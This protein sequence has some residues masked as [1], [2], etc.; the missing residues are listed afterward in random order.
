MGAVEGT[1]AFKCPRCGA[2]TWGNLKFCQECGQYLNVECPGC[3]ATWRYIHER[4]YCP[5]CGTK[6]GKP[7]SKV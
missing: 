2:A 1:G 5:S 6:V 4:S 3:G 7:K